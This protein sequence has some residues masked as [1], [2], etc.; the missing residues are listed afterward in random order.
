MSVT[1][2]DYRAEDA[3]HLA[4]ILH[5]AVRT[6]AARAYDNAQREAWSPA[7]KAPGELHA[8]LAPQTVFV[9]EDEAGA[10]GFMTLA[11]NGHLDMAFVLP[12]VQGRGA[13]AAL[14]AALLDTARQ[15]RLS[16]LH[17]EASHLFRP[18]L[19][20]RGWRLVEAETVTIDGVALERFRM[21]LTL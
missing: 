8:R 17:C 21:T 3:P 19:E 4:A 5:D 11:A 20:K 10:C 1:I 12:R 16:G 6:G 7:P 13:A 9:A 2:R 18:F 15:R 14:Y